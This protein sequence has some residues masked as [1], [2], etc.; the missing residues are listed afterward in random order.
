MAQILTK[1]QNV[2]KISPERVSVEK[3]ELLDLF[4]EYQF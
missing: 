3:E 1:F 4:E 2:K